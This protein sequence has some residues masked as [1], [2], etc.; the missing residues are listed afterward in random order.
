MSARGIMIGATVAAGAGVLAL[1][2][3]KGICNNEVKNERNHHAE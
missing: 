1:G 3:A 2:L